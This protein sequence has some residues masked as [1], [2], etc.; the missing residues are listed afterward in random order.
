MPSERTEVTW[1][2]GISIPE[3]YAPEL[4]PP[5]VLD[6][7][8]CPLVL[9]GCELVVEPVCGLPVD[10]VPVVSPVDVPVLLPV[11]ELLPLIVPVLDPAPDQLL[12]PSLFPCTLPRTS[13]CCPTYRCS[14][15]VSPVRR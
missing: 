9:P 1:R 7:E 2:S 8:V 14:S 15:R 5:M 10:D 12:L 3:P 11:V 4:W 13:T 6:P